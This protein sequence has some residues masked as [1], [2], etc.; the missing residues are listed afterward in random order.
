MNDRKR[1]VLR[2]AQRLFIENG[3]PM[4]SVQQI[5]DEAQISKGTFYN[6]FKSKNDCLLAILQDAY[7]E[8]TVLRRELLTNENRQDPEVFIE[9]VAI[10]LILNREQ[11]L[12]PLYEAVFYS[13]DPDLISYIERHFKDELFWMSDRLHDLFG[14]AIEP[15]AAD[16]TLLFTGMMKQYLH[17]SHP[18]FQLPIDAKKLI[19]FIYEQIEQIVPAIIERNEPFVGDAI[20][21]KLGA[22]STAPLLSK[23]V[24]EQALFTFKQECG[25]E[26]QQHQLEYMSFFEEELQ[27]DTLRT[28][29]LHHMVQLFRR[30]FE[31]TKWE[32]E[33]DA[34]SHLI[35]QYMDQQT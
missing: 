19:T 17:F 23:R 16:V 6:Y 1:Q 8:A 18:K 25:D 9:Q 31:H 29:L 34:L 24:V 11:N 13:G 22:P 2:T 21:K 12:L 26:L 3:F 5:I 14:P 7:E 20:F 32:S 35:W 15:F 30:S 10:R 4:T 27:R 28:T 33:A